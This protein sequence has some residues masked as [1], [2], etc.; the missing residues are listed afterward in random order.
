MNT[1]NVIADTEGGDFSAGSNH[2]VVNVIRYAHEELRE[3]LQQR[4]AVTRRIGTVKQTIVG[5]AKI[6]GDSA[7]CGDLPGLVG[8]GSG[9]RVGITDCCRRLLM[10]TGRPLKAREMCDLIQ[11]TMPSVLANCKDPMATVTTVLTRLAKYGEAQIVTSD[12]GP[13]GWQWS[14]NNVASAGQES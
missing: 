6:F 3:L 7:L 12:L 4:K 1:E 5:L 9:Q 11:R 8:R 2:D 14:S 13:R 10:E